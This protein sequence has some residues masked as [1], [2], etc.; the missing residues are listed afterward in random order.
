[1]IENPKEISIKESLSRTKYAVGLATTVLSEAYFEG[2][3][4]VI[5]DIS[6]KEKFDNLERRNFICLRRPH[7]LLSEL[8]AE[9]DKEKTE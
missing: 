2:R 7:F 8:M 4:V 9:I 6:S 5:D 3:T 1:M